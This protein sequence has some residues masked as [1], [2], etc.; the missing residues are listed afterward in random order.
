M[1]TS[2]LHIFS[3]FIMLSACQLQQKGNISKLKQ[4]DLLFK[5]TQNNSLSS[6]IKEVTPSLDKYSFSHVGVAFQEDGEW[7]VL[8]AIPKA[9]VRITPLGAFLS[10]AK[11][12][13]IKVVAG[14]LKKNYPFDFQ[15]L[16]TY[17]KSQLGKSYDKAF[18]WNEERFYCSELVFQMFANAGQQQAF[19]PQ[20]MTFKEKGTEQFHPTWVLYYQNL[21]VEIPEG[22]LGINPN[23]MAKSKSVQLLFE[24]P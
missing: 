1:K 3:L 10:P 5:D 4:G 21:G 2:L 9:G 22:A 17:G 18:V 8:E 6:A 12:E 13:I 24:L 20:P 14:R 15:K 7:K 11:G 23:A 19:A 16:I